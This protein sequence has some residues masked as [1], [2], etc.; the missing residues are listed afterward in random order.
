MRLIN[1]VTDE[2][3]LRKDKMMAIKLVIIV[4][5]GTVLLTILY[6]AAGTFIL[7]KES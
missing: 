7:D 2:A 4:L 6:Y 5:S 1:P 3:A